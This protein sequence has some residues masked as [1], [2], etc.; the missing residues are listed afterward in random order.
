MEMILF[1]VVAIGLYLVSDYIL[2]LIEIRRGERLP[3]RSVVFFVIFLSL[4]LVSFG[5]IRSFYPHPDD[6]PPSMEHP[7][8]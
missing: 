4:A 6:H 8:Q 2:N 5:L 7:R 1:T 3:N